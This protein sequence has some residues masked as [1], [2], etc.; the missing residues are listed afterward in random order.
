M[1]VLFAS[2]NRAK[3]R[4][5]REIFGDL[6]ELVSPLD[7]G[8]EIDVVED[9]DTFEENARLKAIAYSRKT[10]LLALADDSGLE[11][12]ALDGEPGVHSARYA[13]PEKNSRDN[14]I[15]LLEAL[16]GVQDSKRTA[17]FRCVV[18]CASGDRIICSFSGE[19]EGRIIKEM[20]GEDGFGYDPVFFY[21]PYGKTFAE[22]TPEE[23]NA[24]SHR[25][26]AFRKAAVK[27]SELLKSDNLHDTDTRQ[28]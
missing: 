19:A 23:K 10:G 8:V 24:V 17:R 5:A 2:S 6:L 4:E 27:L 15:K 1:K 14:C 21:E 7:Q 25:G 3:L 22:C 16:D 28:L 12:D 9:G 13:G 18:A 20:R 26:K 11:V